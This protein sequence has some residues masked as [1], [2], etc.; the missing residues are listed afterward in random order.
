MTQTFTIN[1]D[2]GSVT[3]ELVHGVLW[4][5]LKQFGGL[6]TNVQVVEV[7]DG[8]T[9]LLSSPAYG[10]DGESELL[11]SEV[12]QEAQ[13]SAEELGYGDEITTDEGEV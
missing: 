5:Y 6:A 1:W 4:H 13:D 8:P 10:D 2:G 12:A 7:T 11:D 9:T 3:A